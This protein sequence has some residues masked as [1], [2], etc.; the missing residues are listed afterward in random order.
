MQE[1]RTGL[2]G[3]ADRLYGLEPA[4]FTAARNEAAKQAGDPALAAAI[5][6][7]RKPSTSAHLVNLL[8]RADVAA[9]DDLLAIGAALRGA[10]DTG[11][12][13]ELRTL[14]AQRHRSVQMLTAQ[15]G[16]LG[17]G[18]RIS[19]AVAGEISATLQA[20]L[21]DPVA[22]AAVRSGWLIKALSSTGFD[23]VELEGFVALPDELPGLPATRRLRS[24]PAAPT[25]SSGPTGAER[26]KLDQAAERVAVAERAVVKADAA[27][28]SLQ[29][30][31]DAA[32]RGV[33]DAEAALEQ[34]RSV[35][36]AAE[37]ARTAA[38]RDRDAAVRIRNSAKRPT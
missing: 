7:L 33:K 35:L 24:V 29:A 1:G 11:D 34:A 31:V 14:S 5:Q 21:A 20:A 25:G 17:A 12:G 26:K 4:Q 9:V 2:T 30:D 37:K 3:V 8:V 23:T 13:D 6:E 27:L 36:A 28:A 32:K 10:Q 19:D 16:R 18:K 38:R 22:G 15:A